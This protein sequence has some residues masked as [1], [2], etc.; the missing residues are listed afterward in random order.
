MEADTA[1]CKNIT[2]YIIK[3]DDCAYLPNKKSSLHISAPQRIRK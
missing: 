1:A 2:L 3:A